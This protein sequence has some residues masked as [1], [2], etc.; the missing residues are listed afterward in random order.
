MITILLKLTKTVI[1]T[2][3]DRTTTYNIQSTNL[4]QFHILQT[5]NLLIH[6]TDFQK[7]GKQLKRFSNCISTTK[8]SSGVVST[9]A[10]D[11]GGPG[12][13][14]W[15]KGLIRISFSFLVLQRSYDR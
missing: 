6:H 14:S 15:P 9:A 13:N 10:S 5:F 1:Y 4:L 7:K 8:N 2:V 12:L 3:T 11:L